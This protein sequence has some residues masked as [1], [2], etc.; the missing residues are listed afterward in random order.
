[1]KDGW[2]LMWRE[3]RF[4]RGA[5]FATLFVTLLTAFFTAMFFVEVKNGSNDFLLSYMLN[6]VFLLILPNFTTIYIAGYYLNFKSVK[7][8]PL[9]KQMAFYRSLPISIKTLTLSR[10]LKMLLLFILQNGIFFSVFLITLSYVDMELQ[11]VQNLLFFVLFWLGVGLMFGSIIP[12]FE[13]GI[14]T[15]AIF[16]LCYLW[17]LLSLGVHLLVYL[18]L[19]TGIVEFTWKMIA[20]H[21]FLLSIASILLGVVSCYFWFRWLY[22][23]L[24]K[25]DYM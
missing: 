1:M 24:Q 3:L 6:M 18:Q 4:Q 5:L 9:S 14:S 23:R 7:E 13:F 10:L 12:S 25:R 20:Q 19:G 2:W 11:P 15:R 22:Q 16:I 21:G 17:L 8:D